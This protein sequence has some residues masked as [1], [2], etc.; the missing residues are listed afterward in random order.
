MKIAVKY[1]NQLL[2]LILMLLGLAI[3]TAAQ[4]HDSPQWGEK[5]SR[6]MV[7]AETGLPSSFD[8]ATGKNI[9]WS[10]SIGTENYATPVVA[11]GK[12]LIG[13]NN[14]G[15][16]DP[17]HTG[18]RGVLLCLNESDGSLA[19]QLVVPRIEGDR[20]N[21]WPMVGICSPPTVDGNRAYLL[22]NRS[23]V[24]CL[25]LNGQGNGNKD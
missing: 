8:P 22:T 9:K 7:S 6:N 20:H 23:E 25:D 15:E 1:L 10:A 11:G 3:V 17:R 24:L 12:I 5:Y 2:L 19:W 14:A 21:D 4:D 18:D 13:A 16:R